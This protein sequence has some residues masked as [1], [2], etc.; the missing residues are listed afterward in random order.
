V[1]ASNLNAFV[2]ERIGYLRTQ[3]PVEIIGRTI[4]VYRF[5]EA[6][7]GGLSLMGPVDGVPVPACEDQPYSLYVEQP[8]G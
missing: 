3:C 2:G 8:E 1:S 7:W 4:L 6:P 5:E